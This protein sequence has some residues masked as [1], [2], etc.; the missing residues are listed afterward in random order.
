MT[1]P[2]T[3][4]VA[5]QA[6]ILNQIGPTPG[7]KD[8]FGVDVFSLLNETEPISILGRYFKLTALLERYQDSGFGLGDIQ[9]IKLLCSRYTDSSLYF[10]NV[11]AELL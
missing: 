5:V 9:R 2:E 10:N 4:K 3:E 11:F 7:V 1:R 6:A 8:Q